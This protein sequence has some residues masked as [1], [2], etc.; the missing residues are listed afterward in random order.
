MALVYGNHNTKDFI[1]AMLSETYLPSSFFFLT[2]EIL[3][4]CR[5][6]WN[7]WDDD[8]NDDKDDK[9]CNLRVRVDVNVF[10]TKLL[11]PIDDDDDDENIFIPFVAASEKSIKKL[12]RLLVENE[13]LNCSICLENILIGYKATKLTCFHKYHD[14]CVVEWLRVSKFCPLCRFEKT[15]LIVNWLIH[16]IESSYNTG[17]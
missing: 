12:D 9:D 5:D 16:T 17:Y 6:M 8:N 13:R 14:N 1:E 3:N 7:V 4:Y 15:Q 11:D 2:K 10:V